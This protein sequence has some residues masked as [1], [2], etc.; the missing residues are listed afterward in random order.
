MLHVHQQVCHTISDTIVRTPRFT[1]VKQ[2]TCTETWWIAPAVWPMTQSQMWDSICHKRRPGRS[3]SGQR[4]VCA[5]RELQFH[6]DLHGLTEFGLDSCQQRREVEF[7][8]VGPERARPNRRRVRREECRHSAPLL[9]TPAFRLTC[10]TPLLS[11]PDNA[12][13]TFSTDGL[14]F[15]LDHR[16]DGPSSNLAERSST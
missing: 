3:P 11:L 8:C 9:R 7:S 4:C 14:R 12:Q 15:S 2:G 6:R 16:L 5:P 10:P 1:E 13:S